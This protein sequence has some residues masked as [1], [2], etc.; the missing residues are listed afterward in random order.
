MVLDEV[1]GRLM[2]EAD[3]RLNKVRLKLDLHRPLAPIVADAIQIEQVILNL[4][5]NSL[6]AME[7]N[8]Q[9]DRQLTVRTAPMDSSGV[10]IV[11][12]DT[13]A[14][15]PSG[16]AGKVFEPFFTTKSSDMGMGLSISRTIV[17]AHGGR[18][19]VRPNPD[20]GVTFQFTLPAPSGNAS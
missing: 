3:A 5:K 4:A 15:L 19:T 2:V 11:L 10:R 6:E 20:R 13:G 8:S 9:D 12:K 16:A 1:K 18:L 7:H 17:E 14:G